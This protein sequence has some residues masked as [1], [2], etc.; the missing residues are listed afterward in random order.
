M[1][2]TR[3]KKDEFINIAK[4]Y[5]LR[6]RGQTKRQI[7]D[8]LVGLRQQFMTIKEKEMVYPFASNNKNKKLLRKTMKNRPRSKN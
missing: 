6:Y 3:K 4:K 5:G 8:S 2:N 1:T 7:A